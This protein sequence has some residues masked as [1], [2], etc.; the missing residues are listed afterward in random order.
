MEY[1]ILWNYPDHPS[2]HNLKLHKY[3]KGIEAKK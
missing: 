1:K 3:R 2:L